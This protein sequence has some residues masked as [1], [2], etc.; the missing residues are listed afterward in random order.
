MDPIKAF[1]D[2]DEIAAAACN[3]VLQA[4]RES[5]AEHGVFNI[6]LTGGSTPKK[7][8]EL[9]AT[10]TGVEWSKWHFFMGDERF[11]PVDDERS[12]QKMAQD[13]ILSKVSLGPDQIQPVPVDQPAADQ[14]ASIYEQQ[15][16]EYF[17][18]SL[19]DPLPAFDLIL[20]GMGSDGHTAS[21]FPGKL[22]LKETQRLVTASEPGVLPPPVERITF[23]LP[24]INA[25]RRVLFMAAGADKAQ[26]FK[27]V[28]QDLTKIPQEAA[29]PAGMVRPAA[30]KLLWYVDQA[31][32]S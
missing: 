10:Q 30:G 27:H 24:L 31:I 9:L 32:V 17:G 2:A 7:L 1:K 21:L 26:A 14:A 12:N 4:A 22:S 3:Y 5:I 28:C 11:V 20:L 23:T 19:S 16:L 15:I 6:V 25:G 18:I 13:S 29:T 8:Y